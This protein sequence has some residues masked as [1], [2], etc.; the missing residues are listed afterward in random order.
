VPRRWLVDAIRTLLLPEFTR[1]GFE[2]V[3]LPKSGFGPVDRRSIVASRFGMLRRVGPRGI[4]LVE[5]Q[6]APRGRAAFRLHVGVVPP[7]GIET[8]TGHFAAEDVHV[9]WLDEFFE[10]YQS[11]FFWT[12][13]SVRRWPWRKVAR[14][15]HEDL[16]R[17]V[18]GMIPEVE[19]ALREGWRG[20]HLR[21]VDTRMSAEQFS[22][23]SA[24]FAALKKAGKLV[25]Q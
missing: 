25:D 8:I 22:E 20:P 23:M 21:R 5:V 14:T 7:A 10:L 15:D 12:W 13:F 11:A 4:E 18:V 2:I 3:P 16:V 17:R 9:G 19:L 1:R 24:R 6:M